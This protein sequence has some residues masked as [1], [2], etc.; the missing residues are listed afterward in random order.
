MPFHGRELGSIRYWWIVNTVVWIVSSLL[1]HPGFKLLAVP[2]LSCELFKLQKVGS[3]QPQF[4][5]SSV[6]ASLT[7][8]PIVFRLMA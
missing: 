4:F 1:I 3:M 5:S 7:A 8:F 6:S 2:L